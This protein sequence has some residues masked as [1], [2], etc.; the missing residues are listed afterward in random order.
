MMRT[1][2]A[3]YRCLPHSTPSSTSLLHHPFPPLGFWDTIGSTPSTIDWCEPN[4]TTSYYIAEYQNSLSS[5]AI[6]FGGL[7]G[8]Y[9]SIKY[10][11]PR[12]L[13]ILSIL[14]TVVGLGSALFH[15]TLL[16]IPQLL[17][18]LPMLWAMSSFFLIYIEISKSLL[19]T[20]RQWFTW[21]EKRQRTDKS[22]VP[23]LA[24]IN[25][26]LL[27]DDDYAH[28]LHF[29]TLRPFYYLGHLFKGT[30]IQSMVEYSLGLSVTVTMILLSVLHGCFGFVVVFQ[31]SFG[32]ITV[33]GLSAILQCPSLF[34]QPQPHRGRD[35]INTTEEDCAVFEKLFA[36]YRSWSVFYLI[37]AVTA[38]V[39]WLADNF[40]CSSILNSGTIYISGHALWHVLSYGSTYSGVVLAGYGLQMSSIAAKVDQPGLAQL[41]EIHQ[42]IIPQS[43]TNSTAHLLAPHQ[44]KLT[45]GNVREVEMLPCP[46][47]NMFIGVD[48]LDGLNELV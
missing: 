38:F 39:F 37:C 14:V 45:P 3:L 46:V 8:L 44:I 31:T 47:M 22:L 29:Y 11:H 21:A 25:R 33:G 35:G 34:A 30:V 36:G 4:Y 42:T 26:T 16:F 24:G 10:G 28:L 19:A 48:H 9:W 41:V 20:K 18:E 43:T 5:L 23:L 17:D 12:Q 32:L 15:G 2:R 7:M 13:I 27:F 1:K 6:S 40:F